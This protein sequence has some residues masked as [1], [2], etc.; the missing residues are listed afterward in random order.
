MALIIENEDGTLEL[1][2]DPNVRVM[3]LADMMVEMTVKISVETE[4]NLCELVAHTA[5]LLVAN[6]IVRGHVGCT[7]GVLEQIELTI[8]AMTGH[9]E[10]ETAH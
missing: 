2:D 5:R 6:M 7:S 8:E 3:Q 9:V 10:G 1:S 4:T